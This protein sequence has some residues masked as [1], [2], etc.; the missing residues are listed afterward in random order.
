MADMLR[1]M[2]TLVRVQARIRAGR[3]YTTLSSQSCSKSS[4]SHH[5]GGALTNFKGSVSLE[6]TMVGSNRLDRWME[7]VSNNQGVPPSRHRCDDERNAKILEVDIWKPNMNGAVNRSRAFDSTYISPSTIVAFNSPLKYSTKGP[8]T[9]PSLSY[10]EVKSFRSPH[11]CG[12]KCEAHRFAEN[13][14]EAA[15]GL[16]GLRS[17]SGTRRGSFTPA[18]SESGWGFYNGHSGHPNYMSN[19]ESSRAKVRSR[20]A[21]RQRL[22]FG[23]YNSAKRGFSRVTVILGLTLRAYPINTDSRRLL[24]VSGQLNRLG[25]SNMR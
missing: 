1:R 7:G 2:H 10:E 18:K 22:E 6:G 14:Q 19:T 20:S 3:S 11:S 12:V 9:V 13:K 23:T 15:S 16:S 8:N 4:W 17:S 5:R 24:T 25:S 21:P